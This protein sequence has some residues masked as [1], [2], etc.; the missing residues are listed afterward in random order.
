MKDEGF[1]YF[2]IFKF[3]VWGYSQVIFSHVSFT[4]IAE[5]CG[6]IDIKFASG[7]FLT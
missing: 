1:D 4:L 2:A 7:A 6:G 5:L 3:Y